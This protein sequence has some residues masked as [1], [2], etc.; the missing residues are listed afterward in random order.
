MALSLEDLQ[1]IHLAFDL[2]LAAGK[3]QCIFDG[4]P[5]RTQSLDEP[6]EFGNLRRLGFVRPR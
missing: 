6:D 2:S 1:P 4:F 5:I 3:Q